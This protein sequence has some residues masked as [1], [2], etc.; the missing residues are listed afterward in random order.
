M[1]NRLATLTMHEARMQKRYGI[2]YAYGFVL[3]FYL[4]ILAWAGPWLPE[5]AVAVVIFTDPSAL[6]FF[7]LGGLMMLE[8]GENTRTALAVTPVTAGAYLFAKTMTLTLL[9]MAAVTVIWLFLHRQANWPLLMAA[10]A[11]TS[12]Q[13]VGIGVPIALRFRTVTGYL[14]GSAGFL[15]PVIAPGFLALLDPTPWWLLFIPAVSQLKL[16]LVAVGDPEVGVAA[17][18]GML[19]VAAVAAVG[20]VGLALVALR[21]ELG[22]T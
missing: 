7:F 4:A 8:R 11:L 14:I 1:A 20:S 16:M 12:V 13:Y 5:W 2:Y 15:T 19:G 21:R 10:V 6:G 9:A 22:A 3:I 17:I 18:A